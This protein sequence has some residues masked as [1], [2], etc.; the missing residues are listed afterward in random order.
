MPRL[1][2]RR[3]EG[4]ATGKDQ[5]RRRATPQAFVPSIKCL[6][7]PLS[8]DRERPETRGESQ[9]LAGGVL[10]DGAD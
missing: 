2:S 4:W 5:T 8:A 10:W 9:G 3:L 7:G 6:L 1:P